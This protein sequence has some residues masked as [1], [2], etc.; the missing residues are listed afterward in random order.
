MVPDFLKRILKKDVEVTKK[1]VAFCMN[2]V[3]VRS[4]QTQCKVL[5]WSCH[6]II[7]IVGLIAFTY[8]FANSNLYEMEVNLFVALLID[9]FIVAIVKG[10]LA[11]IYKL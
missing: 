8:M 4:F 6:G 10:K 11:I 9:I 2:F 7:W 1:F 5:E 3:Q